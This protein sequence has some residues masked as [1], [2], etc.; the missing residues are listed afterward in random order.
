MGWGDGRTLGRIVG[1]IVEGTTVGCGDGTMVGVVG[2]RVGVGVGL[3]VG[4]GVDA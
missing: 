4:T 3:F 2:R 1:C